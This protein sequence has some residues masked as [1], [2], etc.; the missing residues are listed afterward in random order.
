MSQMD[1]IW[2]PWFHS[3]LPLVLTEISSEP[4][5]CRVKV[6]VLCLVMFKVLPDYIHVIH[7]YIVITGSDSYRKSI[8]KPKVKVNVLSITLCKLISQR[9]LAFLGIKHS[10]LSLTYTIAAQDSN[11]VIQVVCGCENMWLSHHRPTLDK[12]EGPP[13]T[14]N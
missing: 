7:L 3:L 4:R 12:R 1:F 14:L 13:T 9:S 10:F 6:L 11:L 2:Q 5:L 8:N